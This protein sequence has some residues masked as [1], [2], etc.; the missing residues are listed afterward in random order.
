MQLFQPAAFVP[1][2]HFFHL[3]KWKKS[4]LWNYWCVLCLQEL[5]RQNYPSYNQSY[6]TNDLTC[7]Y[8]FHFLW[9]K[10]SDNVHQ[11]QFVIRGDVAK[12]DEKVY[13]NCQVCMKWF[14]CWC[15]PE[16]WQQKTY[17]KHSLAGTVQDVIS[18]WV[19]LA[20][21]ALLTFSKLISVLDHKKKR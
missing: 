1:F 11:I 21:R 15:S 17:P 13:Q 16:T 4:Y 20:S 8:H 6:T 5:L 7:A 19:C 18:W 12:S 2:C 10:S 9:S 3:C 14:I